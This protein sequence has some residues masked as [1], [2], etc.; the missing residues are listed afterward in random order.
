MPSRRIDLRKFPVCPFMRSCEVQAYLGPGLMDDAIR[1]GRLKATISRR[2]F[3]TY[4]T[5]DVV[6]VASG[7]AEGQYPGA[8]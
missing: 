4:K 6:A 7:I 5:A 3:T 1:A 2:K 8:E